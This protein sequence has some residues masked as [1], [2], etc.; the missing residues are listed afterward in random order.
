[1]IVNAT[2]DTT[3]IK[4][5]RS[6]F[7]KTNI[8]NLVKLVPSETYYGRCKVGGKLV[9]ESLKTTVFAV[10]KKKLPLWLI[11][12]R[13]RTSSSDVAMG[14]VIEACKQRL[15]L[16]V[17]SRDI[18]ERTRSTKLECL[19]Q[20]EKVWEELL[21]SGQINKTNYKPGGNH[22][23]KT[24]VTYTEFS[25]TS[26]SA[27]NEAAIERWRAGMAPNRPGRSSQP[28]TSAPAPWRR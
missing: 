10:A 15:N 28:N 24:K 23:F 5:A 17:D 20:I 25:Q 13:G 14:V 2:T 22:Y 21:N 3:D 12:A 27:I 8:P 7:V 6:K 1:L 26:L 9:R 18:R 19:T 16:A 4:P 11:G